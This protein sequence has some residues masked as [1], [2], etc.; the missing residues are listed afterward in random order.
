MVERTVNYCAM[1]TVGH[2]MKTQ[3]TYSPRYFVE[4]FPSDEELEQLKS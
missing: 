3:E 4:N 1:A 2:R